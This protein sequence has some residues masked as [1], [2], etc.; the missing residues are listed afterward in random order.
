LIPTPSRS[1]TLLAPKYKRGLLGRASHFHLWLWRPRAWP[2][3]SILPKQVG[4]THHMTGTPCWRLP[5]CGA[6]AAAGLAVY[7]GGVQ[8]FQSVPMRFSVLAGFDP[9]RLVLKKIGVAGFQKWSILSRRLLPTSASFGFCG[10]PTM[11]I[12]ANAGGISV[13][14]RLSIRGRGTCNDG[15]TLRLLWSLNCKPARPELP[16]LTVSLACTPLPAE[17]VPP[18]LPDASGCTELALPILV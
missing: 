3:F 15:P 5:R 1:S 11:A 2:L 7:H 8:D 18:T 4:L 10:D 13:R 17:S 14:D 9:P 6:R 12:P 16:V